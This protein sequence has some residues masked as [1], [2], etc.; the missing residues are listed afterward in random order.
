M[1]VTGETARVVGIEQFRAR[2]A[3]GAEVAFPLL[4]TNL[5]E[6]HGGRWLMALHHASRLPQ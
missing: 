3:S 4:T 6:R 5:Y 2:S 1:H